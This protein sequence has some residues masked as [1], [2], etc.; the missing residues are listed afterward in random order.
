MRL[1]NSSTGVVVSTSEDTATR[2]GPEWE[3]VAAD[4]PKP[5][6]SRSKKTNDS[7]NDES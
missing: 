1:R 7:S 4:R 2:L 6:R 5:T 3:P